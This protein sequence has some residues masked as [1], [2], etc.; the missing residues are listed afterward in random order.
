MRPSHAFLAVV[1][2]LV[3]FS[4]QGADAI[5]F[6]RDVRP[7]LSESCFQCH[8]PDTAKREAD[9]RLDSREGL[10]RSKDGSTVV[11]PGDPEESALIFR[12]ESDDPELV[13]PPP[14]SGKSL[15]RSQAET[16]RRWVAEGAAFQGHWAYV[17]P[18]RPATPDVSALEKSAPV[19]FV[20]NDVDRFILDTLASKGL[21]PS[22]EADRITLIRRLYFDLIGLPPTPAE[23]DAF[24]N[25]AA[26]D[27][28]EKLV[29]RVL[30]SPHHGERLAS[31]WLDL[32]RYADTT[33]YHGDN[34]REVSLYRD[35]VIDAFNANK[36]FDAFTVEQLAG[37]LLP[38]P[39]DQQRIASG[40]N[41]MLMTT[42]EGGA[43][44]KEYTA[45]YAADR[46]RNVSTVWLGSTLGCA[47]CHDHKY[48]PFT[49]RDFYQFAAFF[50]D[51]QEVAVGPQEEV[52]FPTPEQSAAIAT[53]DAEIARLQKEIESAPLADAQAD[54]EKSASSEADWTVLTPR[55]AVSQGGA[56]LTV[57]GDGS[58][59][60]SGEN[61]ARDTYRLT[62]AAPRGGLNG[63]KLELIPDGSLPGLGPGRASNGNFVLTGL[64]LT[65]ETEG[66]KAVSRRAVA[67]SNASATFAQGGFA[68]AGA[69]DDDPKTGWAVM[70]ETGRPNQAVFES[71]EPFG[72]IGDDPSP[73]SL[74]L[75]L[76]FQ[77]GDRHTLGR[78]R[79]LATSAPKPLRPAAF[80]AEVT[81][82]LKVPGADRTDAQ[83]ATLATYYRS[84][85]PGLQPLRDAVAALKGRRAGVESAMPKT[86]VTRSGEPR[87]MRVLPRGN[88][89]DESGP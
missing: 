21:T 76:R 14:K 81:A 79:L 54:W 82:A 3:P 12:I 38:N 64:S 56:T 48:D 60:A 55:S 41:N 43:Q 83:R 58:V 67:W 13:M 20:R 11:V 89:L 66:D 68:V 27:A 25:D 8:G 87:T 29:D 69:I 16:I 70:G 10:F 47:E 65:S 23:V 9:L 44:A 24:V 78:F 22:P 32:V 37:D 39:T 75:T 86:V 59:L 85:A 57:K 61:P 53:I 88:W 51:I 71:K 73:V 5:D 18:V 74:T 35:W 46:V 77:H 40:Y 17:P 50:A 34:H 26:P 84:I 28:Y 80:P 2:V 72:P 62:F 31:W 7:I 63:L 52:A 33:G 42:R 45:K 15:T 6:N 19:G 36:R 49:T 1:L 4:A 30:A